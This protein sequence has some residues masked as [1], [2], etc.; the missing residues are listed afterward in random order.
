MTDKALELFDDEKELAIQVQAPSPADLLKIAVSQNADLDKLEKLMELQERFE[1]REAKKAFTK[2]VSGFRAT[3]PMIGK[4]RSGHNNKYAGLA[5][6]LETI[7][8]LLHKSGLSHSWK[9][10]Q[11][12]NITT[13]TCILAHI[14]GHSESTSL[15]APSDM[16][17]SKNAI[18]AIGST[19]S[20]LERYT[21]F[22]ILG[23]SSKEL[24]DDGTAAGTE[25]ITDN[26]ARDL[27]ALLS[28]VNADIGKFKKLYHIENLI[29]LPLSQYAKAVKQAEGKRK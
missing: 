18:Q 16:T 24:D 4:T 3:C 21:L 1:N 2:A 29:D 17:G 10:S 6:T 11:V 13:V 8:P 25:T 9:T 15:S 26:Q 27:Q 14:D 28:E 5:E 19:V 23:I 22:A 7:K 12:E 20:Y